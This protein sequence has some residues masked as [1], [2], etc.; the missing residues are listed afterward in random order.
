MQNET[1]AI[2]SSLRN[3][4][5][6]ESIRLRFGFGTIVPWHSGGPTIALPDAH[7]K[8]AVETSCCIWWRGCV[9]M[10]RQCSFV[11]FRLS[12]QFQFHNLTLSKIDSFLMK[13][14]S[15]I[16]LQLCP[17][18]WLRSVSSFPIAL[19]FWRL[20]FWVLYKTFFQCSIFLFRCLLLRVLFYI[21]LFLESPGIPLFRL[22]I[23]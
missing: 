8:S 14:A 7:W 18:S 20:L 17:L 3:R 6:N 22:S 16:A 4:Y 19:D 1:S 11:W 21:E 13:I 23:V 9:S 2:H 12:P 10:I 15:V 5:V